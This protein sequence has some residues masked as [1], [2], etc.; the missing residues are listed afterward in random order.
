MQESSISVERTS[1]PPTSLLV[2]PRVI[3]K[4]ETI[5][6]LFANNSAEQHVQP[7]EVVLLHGQSADRLYQ[8]ISGTVR[9]CT[10]TSQGRRQIFR[11]ALKGELLGFVDL[12]TWHFTAEAVDHV[13][14]RSIPRARMEARLE[15]EPRLQRA[16]RKLVSAELADRE[17][18]MMALA[19]TQADQRLRSFLS[20]FAKSRRTSGFV[21]LPMTRQDIGDHLGLTLET[22][23]RAFSSLKRRGV[24]EMRGSERFRMIDQ[25]CEVE[26]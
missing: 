21:T 17:R 10:F 3:R 1:T 13:I 23:S 18:Q 12:E 16:V 19:Y 14:L 7:G 8:I 24:L 11:F 15:T 25:M 26:A 20:K 4:P 2:A 22:V 6:D 9:C 5:S